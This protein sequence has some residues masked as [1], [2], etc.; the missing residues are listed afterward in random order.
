MLQPARVPSPF[1]VALIATRDRAALL[2]R[3]IASVVAQ[4]RLPDALIVVEDRRDVG[5]DVRRVMIETAFPSSVDLILL[6]NRRTPGA[7]GAWNSGLDEAT[8]RFAPAEAIYVAI[9]DDD[10]W[11]DRDHI[12][13]CLAHAVARDLDMVAPCIVRHDDTHPNGRIQEPPAVLS[14]NI[15]FMRNPHIQGSSLFA[16]LSAL[17]EAGMFDES[18]RSTTDRDLLVR[19]ADMN[20]NYAP[21]GR[22]TVHHDARG[23]RPRLSTAGSE[24]KSQGLAQFWRKYRLR[25]NEAQRTEFQTRAQTLFAT[26]VTTIAPMPL[27]PPFRSE[28]EPVPEL[29]GGDVS[30]VLV[31]GIAADG[32][33][34]GAARVTPL[35]GDLLAL[36]S[37]DRL[38][39]LDVV[40]VENGPGGTALRSRVDEMIARGLRCYLADV[41]RQHQDAASGFFGPGFT[42]RQG[43]LGISEARAITQRYVRRLMRPGSIAWLL[44]D[45]KRLVPLVHEAG[46]LRR[47][48][49]DV[50][51][52]IARLRSSGAAVVLGID[53]G[54]APLP[55][56]ATLRTQLV[57]L[58][59][60]LAVM[61]ALGP[62]TV[63]PDGTAECVENARAAPDYYHD[64]A[65]PHTWHLELPFWFRPDGAEVRVRDAFVEL[66]AR[67]PRILAGEQIFRPLFVDGDAALALRPSIRRGGNTLV[68]DADALVDV[69]QIVP[70]PAG[71]PTRRSDM[72]WALLQ[73]HIRGRRVEE[74]PFAVFHD[75][76]DADARALDVVTL[77]D[78]IRGY[79]LYSMLRDVVKRWPDFEGP[80]DEMSL[81]ARDR[82]QKY[83]IERTA[84]FVVSLYR[85]RGAARAARRMAANPEVWW[86]ARTDVREHAEGLVAFADRVLEILGGNVLDQVRAAVAD[87]PPLAIG[88]YLRVLREKLDEAA[89]PV[90][91]K[92]DWIRQDRVRIAQAQIERLATPAGALRLLGTGHEGVVFTDERK[93]FK[94]LDLWRARALERDRELLRGLI[95]KWTGTEGLYPLERLIE[96]GPHAILV[97]TY[98]PTEPYCGGH[99]AG[100]VGLLRECREHGIV[101]RNLHPRNLRV[102]GD[103]VR[104]VDYGADLALLDTNEWRH[105]TRRAWLCWRWPHHPDLEGLMRR[106]L[107]EDVPELTGCERLERAVLAPDARHELDALVLDAVV[108]AAPSSVLDFGCGAGHLVSDLARRGIRAVGYD[109]EVSPH[110]A[111]SRDPNFTTDRPT[112]LGGAPYDV[113]V[114]SLVLCTIE[115]DA[116]YRAVLSDLRAAVRDGGRVVI[117]VCNPFHTMGGDTPSQRRFVPPGSDPDRTF[118]W[119][120]QVHGTGRLRRDIHRPLHVLRRDLLRAGL[121]VEI[122][123]ETGAVDLARLEPA[124]DFMVLT[125]RA[126]VSRSRVSLLVRTSALE[127]RTLATQLRHLVSQLEGP[128]A[129]HERVAV[130]DSRQSG[131]VRQYD[132]ADMD[133]A[134]SILE[135]LVAEGT[136]DRVVEVPEAADEISALHQRWFGVAATATHA[137]S[138]VPVAASLVG[139][140]ACTGDHILHV[141]DDLL[142][143][144]LDRSHDYLGELVDVLERDPAAICASLNICHEH[145]QPWTLGGANGPWRVEVRGTLLHRRRLLDVRPLPNESSGPALVRTWYRALDVRIREQALHSVRGGRSATFFIHPPNDRKHDRHTWFAVLDRMETGHV[146]SIQH[147]SVDLVGGLEEWLGPRRDEKIIVIA[148]GRN[149]LAGRVARF[150]DALVAQSE[151][152]WGLVV[153]EDGGSQTSA[154]VVRS[155]FGRVPNA[156]VLTLR[157]RRGA[158]ANIVWTLRYVCSNPRSIIVLADLDDA[159]LGN[160]A[161]ARVAMEF[162]RGADLTVGGML[163]TDKA[164]Q[165]PVDFVRPR[166]TRGGNVWQHLRAFRRELFDG[167]PDQALRLDGEYVDL[168]WDWALMLALVERATAPRYIDETLYLYEPS[169]VGKNGEERVAREQVIARIVSR[170]GLRP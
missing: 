21:L 29:P 158:L 68:F 90:S 102:R 13:A 18:L 157:E 101:F 57:D 39:A 116:E 160:G 113:A 14:A 40:V 80:G 110:W 153:V 6:G 163:R 114:C 20:V 75:R 120:K 162:E 49:F 77:I 131:F 43:R 137:V 26:D 71:R 37:E 138:G 62:E 1:V 15:V 99:A 111:E 156:T 109:P 159:L 142:V 87:T 45:D 85:S 134:R 103:R 147:G 104:L 129:F 64:L 106:A 72:V 8:R 81:F 56:A 149:V 27:A 60:N 140:E 3:A 151:R 145:D 82:Y 47:R 23:D 9:L 30:V 122:V 148:C 69:P 105:M 79:A 35:L 154:D 42:R 58:A 28:Q 164:K 59:A 165:Y 124:S 96:S 133:A 143:A 144:R 123:S 46:S 34:R 74:A 150:R 146:P 112:A 88:E 17:L 168:A 97:Y 132:N 89:M 78:D 52:T 53:T 38:A 50:V 36:Q 48:P 7:S 169:G 25:M 73:V 100:I 84:A 166:Q 65:R 54:A 94:Y 121:L 127:W 86:N 141:D 170:P 83:L 33:E 108:Q 93:V 10:D 4:T 128:Q 63:W 125:A 115:D 12:T 61:H 92:P 70:S 11:W 167:V 155:N 41:E 135:A 136:M 95:G 107:R 130:L 51:E 5:T 117:S 19:L 24:A 55:A 126:V 32:D 118:A 67:V 76:S 22:A 139:F 16:R 161:L 119:T 91:V 2:Q 31:V 44:D 98:E 152:D 66:C